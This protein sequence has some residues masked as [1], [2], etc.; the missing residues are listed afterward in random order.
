MLVLFSLY[1]KMLAL[2]CDWFTLW[3]VLDIVLRVPVQRVQISLSRHTIRSILVGGGS[4]MVYYADEF[5]KSGNKHPLFCIGIVW[6]NSTLI[7]VS[8][9]H[10]TRRT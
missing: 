4:L 3:V 8:F 7:C 9:A 2:F 1:S 6:R 5:L 10:N